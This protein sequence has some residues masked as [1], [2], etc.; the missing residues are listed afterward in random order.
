LSRSAGKG[1]KMLKKCPEKG[2]DYENPKAL[3]LRGEGVPPRKK[4]SSTK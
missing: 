4:D 1:G 3:N 2:N